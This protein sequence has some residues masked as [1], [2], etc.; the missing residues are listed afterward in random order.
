MN[1]KVK[2]ITSWILIIGSTIFMFAYTQTYSDIESVFGTIGY[3]IPSA[4][5][6]YLFSRAR[7]GTATGMLIGAITFSILA[8][9]MALNY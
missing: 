4:L 8:V 2:K 1:D 9:V 7:K 3:L 5:I 6:G